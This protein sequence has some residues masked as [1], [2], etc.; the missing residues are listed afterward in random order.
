MSYSPTPYAQI[1]LS[2]GKPFFLRVKQETEWRLTGV[3]VRKDG[4]AVVKKDS[5]GQ[6]VDETVH[7]IDKLC[8]V[9]R[10]PYVMN[11]VFAELERA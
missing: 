4:D 9:K 2:E 5:S 1:T 6:V 8:I 11:N 3:E 7:I 10:V